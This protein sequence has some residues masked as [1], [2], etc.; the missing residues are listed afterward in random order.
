ME[1]SLKAI[2]KWLRKS[3][4][5]VNQEKTDLGLFFKHDTATVTISEGDSIIK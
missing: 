1:K 3:G 4:L 2:T 5:K